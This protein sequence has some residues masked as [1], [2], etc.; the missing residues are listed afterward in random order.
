MVQPWRFWLWTK[1]LRRQPK[2][3][4]QAMAYDYETVMKRDNKLCRF[5]FTGCSRHATR[6]ELDVPEYLGGPSSDANARAV[7]R[8][9]AKQL[10]QQRI[11]AA[12]LFNYTEGW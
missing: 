4:K 9:C 12:A 1:G 7:C 2:R 6:I 3:K 10:R 11:R 8:D 5:R